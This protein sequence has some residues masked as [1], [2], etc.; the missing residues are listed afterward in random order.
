MEFTGKIKQLLPTS[1]YGA[2]NFRK[3][4]LV[5]TTNEQY[6]QHIMIE[7]HQD[8]CD[9]L[10]K[11]EVGQDVKIGTNI[12]GKEWISPEGEARYF[13]S[14]VGWRIEDLGSA[15]P[16]ASQ[17]KQPVTTQEPEDLPF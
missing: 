9:V 1:S 12:R 13:N 15:T 14:I 6:P 8:K 2:S 4:S 10:N 11:Y 16:T 7:F 3:R 5:I 17:P